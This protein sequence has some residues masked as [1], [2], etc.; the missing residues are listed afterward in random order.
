MAIDQN[1]IDTID[2]FSLPEIAQ[3][4]LATMEDE[5]TSV[6]DIDRL[7]SKDF[8][9]SSRLLKVANTVF[10]RRSGEVSTVFNAL[11]TVGFNVARSLLVALSVRDLCRNTVPFER[12]IWEHNLGVSL[13]SHFLAQE[14]RYPVPGEALVTGLIHDIGKAVLYRSAPERYSRVIDEVRERGASFY[15]AEGEMLGTDHCQVGGLVMARWKLPD[16]IRDAVESHHGVH[17]VSPDGV[18][19]L[20]HVVSIADA[21]CWNEGIGFKRNGEPLWTDDWEAVGLSRD[22]LV[23]LGAEVKEIYESQK[24][25]LLNQ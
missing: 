3:K 8:V 18:M 12:S 21:L 10:F 14:C 19:R 16:T 17:R 24:Q 5:N 13:F 4:V 20:G 6:E 23:R 25:Y 7:V 2:L 11:M 22:G 1:I 15:Q 9:L